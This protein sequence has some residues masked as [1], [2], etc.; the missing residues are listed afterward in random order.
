MVGQSFGKDLHGVVHA[1]DVHRAAVVPLSRGSLPL[2]DT[3][4][5]GRGHGLHELSP[6]VPNVHEP[7]AERDL[8]VPR[9]AGV[10]GVG[11]CHLVAVD[12]L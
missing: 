1:V 4:D 11:V 7:S 8:H 12:E 9:C 5:G 3:P 2:A 10:N 6:E